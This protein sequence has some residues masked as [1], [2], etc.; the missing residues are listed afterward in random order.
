YML[1]GPIGSAVSIASGIVSDQMLGKQVQ[2]QQ[3]LLQTEVRISIEK[4]IQAYFTGVSRRI[5]S[6]YTKMLNEFQ[7]QQISWEKSKKS[8]LQKG[9]TDDEE[10]QWRQIIENAAI[11]NK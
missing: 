10:Q 11:L 4:S 1:F 2:Q 8:L 6:L 9:V 5:Q 3:H 7:Q